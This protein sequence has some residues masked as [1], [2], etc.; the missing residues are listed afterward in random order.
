MS[1]SCLLLWGSE[2]KR[3]E[4]IEILR[5]SE[6]RD[7]LAPVQPL[8]VLAYE[9][10]L[11]AGKSK[12]IGKDPDNAILVKKNILPLLHH[13]CVN[14][15]ENKDDDG[16]KCVCDECLDCDE[17]TYYYW[18]AEQGKKHTIQDI[19]D[20]EENL[21]NSIEIGPFVGDRSGQQHGENLQRRLMDQLLGKQLA[22]RVKLRFGVLSSR[23]HP[24]AGEPGDYT[25]FL[26][27]DSEDRIHHWTA[28]VYNSTLAV[29]EFDPS[30]SPNEL[31]S[32]AFYKVSKLLGFEDVEP[33]FLVA[34]E[35]SYQ[36]FY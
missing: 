12:E 18:P 16:V 23:E 5:R 20:Y 2:L 15:G 6:N 7:C 4:G 11:L 35:H 28:G 10:A 9:A 34:W 14:V 22:A 17:L 27:L 33:K 21:R 8:H 19:W 30:A 31:E 1:S 26:F 32:W 13:E 24:G 29:H 3:D 25:M 36:S